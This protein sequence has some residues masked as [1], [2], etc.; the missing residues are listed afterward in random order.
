MES[1]IIVRERYIPGCDS[2]IIPEPLKTF[3]IE[4]SKLIHV[5]IDLTGYKKIGSSKNY[6]Y[7]S[8]V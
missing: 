6:D 2:V 1:A 7:Y 3:K 5:D 4:G 8:T